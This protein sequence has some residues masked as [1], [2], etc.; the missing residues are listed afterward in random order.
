MDSG[1][2]IKKNKGMIDPWIWKM[3]WRDARHNT[4]RLFLF[5]SAII[6]GIAALVAI[7]S[8][9][10]NLLF[11]ID[12]QA[13]ELLGADLVADANRKFE[14]ELLSLFDS[15]QLP[16]SQE[17]SFASMVLFHHS[18][19]TRLIR[20]VALKGGFPYYGEVETSP[21]NQYPQIF[22]GPF[23]ILDENLANQYNV[24]TEDSIKIGNMNFYVKGE[25]TKIP[26][27]N[28]VSTSFTPSI[29]ISLDYLE[30][31]GLVQFGSRVNYKRYFKTPSDE[32]ALTLA[33]SLEPKL[34]KYG[35]RLET[36]DGRKENL[37]EGL[38]N[39]YKFFNL[40]AF[41]ALILGCIGIAS[42]VH[43]YSREKQTSVAVLR[44][45]GVSGWQAFYIYLIQ[46]VIIG[47][48]GSVLG[49]IIG[50]GIQFGLP[51]I[52][53]NFLPIDIHVYFVPLT[54]IEGILMGMII[55][56][57]FAVVPLMNV[58]FVPPLNALRIDFK[59][60]RKWS[61]SRFFVGILMVLFPF[62]FAAWQS[63]SWLV[64]LYFFLGLAVAFGCLYGLSVL[65]IRLIK[66]Y[67]PRKSGFIIRQSLA[68]L[69]RPNNQ[70]TVLM[71]VIG[72]GAFLM[73][74]MNIVQNSLLNQVEFVGSENQ[75]NTV[76]FDI[77]PHQKDGVIELT[78][79]NQLP[80]QQIVPIITCRLAEINGKS[81]QQIQ[82]DT[83]DDVPNWAITRE[84][85]VTYRD[86]LH[87]SEEL[88]EGEI[89]QVKKVGN[90][91]EI[92]VT[93]SNGMQENLGLALG[94]TVVFDVQ[95]IPISTRIGGI[96][97][98]DW[99]QDPP[100]FIFVFPG[101][102][103]EEAPQIYVLTTRVSNQV[104]S[105]K[106]SREIVAK[107]PNIS[108]LDL[109]LILKTIDEFFQKVAFIIQFMALFSILTGL[110]VLAGAVLNS[111]YAR[112]KENVLLR[113]MGASK[114]QIISLTVVEYISL[115]ILA[116]LV[117][118][119]LAILAG[120][121]LS[122]YLFEVIFVPDI[123]GLIY[124]WLTVTLLTVFVG[125]WNTRSILNHSPLEV[126]RREL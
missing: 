79:S 24:S 108:L 86:S 6:I 116:G 113:T 74:T 97:E 117:G 15:L 90:E 45:L 65:F 37:G 49:A 125:W 22:S 122:L 54:F 55:S 7:N 91:D 107:F 63:E 73:A 43:I 106:Y 95:G 46:I 29:Y 103:L 12:Q 2:K 78:T 104:I 61:K 68:N 56:A 126:L 26:G 96:R 67:F 17:A 1:G 8:F 25:V 102:V 34:R 53:S 38:A 10:Q 42:S 124:I 50:V 36:V 48:I 88:L 84:Y 89:Q 98:V 52:L 64:G 28:V 23:A 62:L 85:R 16:Q 11:D 60:E 81:V 20:V 77:Q 30:S 121:G 33:D 21:P 69:F 119:G 13:K 51:L 32:E 19:Q 35:Y 76:L 59:G 47:T 5:I 101:N 66:K 70:T 93:I 115:G 94:D 105:D 110:I 111:K 99:P 18:G 40:L 9:H 100:N 118:I 123:L 14:P 58:R 71:V 87:A 114:R 72:L 92:W 83:T 82:E 41:I 3:A 44:C 39:L 57:L 27:G 112:L 109:R 31:T 75:S 4:G 120:W 80:V